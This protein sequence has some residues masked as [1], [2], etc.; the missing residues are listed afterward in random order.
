MSQAEFSLKERDKLR[1]IKDRMARF[2]VTAGGVG[3]LFALLLIFFYLFSIALPVFSS[4]EIRSVTQL[5]YPSSDT[6]VA[7]GIDD[8][9]ENG[10]V[11]TRSGELF[12]LSFSAN[13]VELLTQTRITDTPDIFAKG[14]SAQGWF[15]YGNSHGSVIAVHPHYTVS[16]SDVGRVSSPD[17]AFFNQGEPVLLDKQLQPLSMLTFAITKED[18]GTFAGVTRSSKLAAVSVKAGLVTVLSLPDIRDP[19]QTLQLSPDGRQLF[20]LTGST[21]IVSVREDN[22]FVVRELIDVSRG[23]EQKVPLSLTL[24]AGARS[25]LITH[26]DHTVSQWFDVLAEG[27]RRLTYIREFELDDGLAFIQPDMYR[28]GFY[29]FYADG[30]LES[31]YTTNKNRVLSESVYSRQPDMVAISANESFLL[32]SHGERLSIHKVTNPYPDIS[33]TSLWSK[34]WYENYPEPDYIWQSTS[35]DDSFETKFSLIPLAFGTL[36]AAAFAMLISVPLAICGAVYTAYFMSAPMRRVVKPVIEIMEAL[37]TVI[38]GFLAGLWLAPIVERTLPGIMALAIVMPLA[39]LL[40]AG[41]WSALPRSVLNRLPNGWHSIIL[42]PVVVGTGFAAVQM[43]SDIER[44]LFGGD[45]RLFMAGYGIHFDQRNALVVGIAMGFAVIPTI[46]TIA[47]DAIFS[48]PKHLTDGSLALGATQWQT[49][50]HVVLLTASPGIFS[51]V[52]IGLGRAV[53]ETMIVLMATGNTP[54]LDWNIFEGMRSLSATI[55]VELPESEV[56]NSHYRLLFLS[57]LILFVF[58]FA[59]NSLAEVVRQRLRDKYRSL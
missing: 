55:A 1:Y 5:V 14:N 18:E 50:L 45:I 49:L 30:T 6:A 10:Y 35:A 39:F 43:S 20:I 16:F 40:V 4:A 27:E 44:W 57:A 15:A 52:M 53:G 26:K 37:P 48:V 42:I 17:I 46:F 54:I 29:A 38:I 51:A 12:Y 31:I 9:G 3:V 21:L 32:T 22:G 59:V 19:V 28:K 8:Y 56:G 34:V 25:V 58:T 11:L 13:N 24:L 47:E 2:T 41:M 23:N 36:K 33:F 7:L